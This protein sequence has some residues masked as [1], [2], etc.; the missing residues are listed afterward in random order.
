MCQA[1]RE[2][3]ERPALLRR[4]AAAAPPTDVDYEVVWNGG[5]GLTSYP[6]SNRS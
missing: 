2:D 5:E 3:P 6:E 4:I 1:T